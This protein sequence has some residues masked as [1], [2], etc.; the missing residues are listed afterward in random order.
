[1]SGRDLTNEGSVAYRRDIQI[2]DEQKKRHEYS[3]VNLPEPKKT[4][5][6][7]PKVDLSIS[8]SGMA[9]NLRDEGEGENKPMAPS[10]DRSELADP[11][12]EEMIACG[13]ESGVDMVNYN[14]VKRH[15]GIEY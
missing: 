11:R 8:A 9:G 2:L 5:V 13:Y 1:M 12:I 15:L 3:S 14:S 7:G 4:I 6:E 10:K